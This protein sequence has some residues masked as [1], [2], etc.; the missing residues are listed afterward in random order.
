MHPYNS[1]LVNVGTETLAVCYGDLGDKIKLNLRPGSFL[2][3]Q[4][5]PVCFLRFLE[6]LSFQPFRKDKTLRHIL[7]AEGGCGG[8]F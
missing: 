7:T 1:S 4:C 2:M 6:K 8:R 5:N 3:L